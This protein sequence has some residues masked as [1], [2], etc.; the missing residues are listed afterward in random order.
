MK[1][2]KEA[3]EALVPRAQAAN[4]L[5]EELCQELL[6]ENRA[7]TGTDDQDWKSFREALR[8][9][10]RQA[11]AQSLLPEEQ[12]IFPSQD[13][14]NNYSQEQEGLNG[15]PIHIDGLPPSPPL[16]SS[17]SLAN[18]SLEIPEL[19]AGPLRL[20]SSARPAGPT[21]PRKTEI[22]ENSD[23]EENRDEDA[24]GQQREKKQEGQVAHGDK[25]QQD[26]GGLV[27]MWKQR[28][29]V[30]R[31]C[32]GFACWALFK[33]LRDE[34]TALWIA[35]L[36]CLWTAWSQTTYAI[37]E[38]ILN[39]TP[40]IL[41]L[42]LLTAIAVRTSNSTTAPTPTTIVETKPN[43]QQPRLPLTLPPTHLQIPP[44]HTLAGPDRE[45]IG[46]TPRNFNIFSPAP[47]LS[48]PRMN[49]LEVLE[50]LRA[51][52]AA[53]KVKEISREAILA[54]RVYGS[55]IRGSRRFK[56]LIEK[57]NEEGSEVRKIYTRL[58]LATT[59]RLGRQLGEPD[60]DAAWFEFMRVLEST[61]GMDVV[62]EGTQEEVWAE[63]DANTL[64][65]ADGSVTRFLTQHILQRSYLFELKE[66]PYDLNR[67]AR[68]PTCRAERDKI[69]QN[70]PEQ[71]DS[72]CRRFDAE[73]LL[74]QY[75]ETTL[76]GL[77]DEIRRM[78]LRDPT[79][80]PSG[81]QEQGGTKA[82]SEQPAFTAPSLKSTGKKTCLFHGE[83]T[84]P[85]DECYV[86][87][88]LKRER[89]EGLKKK[90]TR[91]G[92]TG[93]QKGGFKS[94]KVNG[95]KGGAAGAQQLVMWAPVQVAHSAS[96]SART[97]E[98]GEEKEETRKKSQVA[99]FS[100]QPLA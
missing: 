42:V 70:L 9:R 89:E 38:S 55:P 47:A 31:V 2:D 16:P 57:N 87:K 22:G 92:F 83:C 3:L 71:L 43:N 46:I 15:L 78:A 91:T 13:G 76:Q 48:S 94:A 32:V 20:F 39:Y 65:K 24:L 58:I 7:L 61:S 36:E 81:S 99:R 23:G 26:P 14:N 85:T 40:D 30:F 12:N 88:Q 90:G 86:A 37:K 79:Q 64:Q 67:R 59:A 33:K 18:L 1:W 84:H 27:Q 28:E 10:T 21:P 66:I 53:P 52:A 19:Q 45:S 5:T 82:P 77:I 63:Y 34:S 69:L 6:A 97:E 80:R 74:D 93:Q 60:Y 44:E 41:A 17:S 54:L 98:T 25:R 72:R 50:N 100:G 95:W 51:A 11:T 56:N 49:T 75:P 68:A 8:Y 62:G 96:E 35:L 29:V 73:R 4:L